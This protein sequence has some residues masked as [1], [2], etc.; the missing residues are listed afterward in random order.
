MDTISPTFTC[1]SI[2]SNSP[3]AWVQSVSRRPV[4]A[5]SRA[6]RGRFL[7]LV[8]RLPADEPGGDAVRGQRLALEQV[9]ADAVEDQR[10]AV[11]VLRELGDPVRHQEDDVAG[12]GEE[13]HPAEEVLRLLLGERRVRL[14]EEEDPRVAGKRAADLDPL[15]DRQRDVAE[16]AVGYVE[17]RQVAHQRA[18]LLRSGGA[19]SPGSSRARP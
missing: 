12:I 9:G 11:R 18:L 10:D 1:R 2:P 4:S 5:R 19:P 8:G 3:P 7:G 6:R 13:V 16:L 15:L 14:V 17:D